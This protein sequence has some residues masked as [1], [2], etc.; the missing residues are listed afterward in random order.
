[1]SKIGPTVRER[2]SSKKPSVPPTQDAPVPEPARG[3]ALG[4]RADDRA[5]ERD[6]VDGHHGRADLVTDQVDGA[7]VAGPQGLVVRVGRRGVGELFRQLEGLEGPGDRGDVVLAAVVDALAEGVVER[8]D[9]LVAELVAGGDDDPHR[10]P[11]AVHHGPV[12]VGEVATLVED[13]Q[14]HDRPRDV[15]GADLLDLHHPAGG[16]PRPGAQGVEPELCGVAL[17]HGR[18][19]AIR[20]DEFDATGPRDRMVRRPSTTPDG[21]PRPYSPARRPRARHEPHP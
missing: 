1:M 13:G 8:L 12:V 9:D 17:G 19:P 20:P 18:H 2:L 10:A 5:E 4:G 14:A 3:L 15:D 21:V 6:A 11:A 16:H 7:L